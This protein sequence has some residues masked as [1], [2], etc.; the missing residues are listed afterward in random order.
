M[1][2]VLGE[3]A[4]IDRDEI[5]ANSW[6]GKCCHAGAEKKEISHST[7][8][9]QM[10]MQITSYGRTENIFRP[11]HNTTS[12]SLYLW[13]TSFHVT[14][15]ASIARTLSCRVSICE[16]NIIFATYNQHLPIPF[17]TCSRASLVRTF[18]FASNIASSGLVCLGKFS[19]SQALLEMYGLSLGIHSFSARP[20][21]LKS[22]GEKK[23]M[24][25]CN[26]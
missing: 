1:E 21:E 16:M 14:F 8:K 2:A 3:G 18:P 25:W 5:V 17:Y 13:H 10:E 6:K 9:R 24:Y 22:M 7:N 26:L 4:G 20:S 23:Y 15:L 12:F 19:S 11:V